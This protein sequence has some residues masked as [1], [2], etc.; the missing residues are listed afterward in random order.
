MHVVSIPVLE[1]E[2]VSAPSILGIGRR[3]RFYRRSARPL[4]AAAGKGV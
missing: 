4:D 2:V 1:S 3:L